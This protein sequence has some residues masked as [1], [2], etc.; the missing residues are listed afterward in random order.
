MWH[1][2]IVQPHP[3]TARCLQ[4]TVKALEKKG[5]SI[6]SWDPT[7]HRDLI[8]CVD[9]AYF[10]D[11]G[12]EYTGILAAGDEPATHL[13]KWIL[14]KGAPKAYTASETWKVRSFLNTLLLN[15]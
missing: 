3:P 4:E 15:V 12:A 8:N 1:D 2:G 14:E 5:H 9:R 10:L 13:M 11:G 7:L 6:I